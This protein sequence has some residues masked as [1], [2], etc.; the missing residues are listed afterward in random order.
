MTIDRFR[1][2]NRIDGSFETRYGMDG[3]TYA[4]L[5]QD[6]IEEAGDRSMPLEELERE[7]SYVNVTIPDLTDEQVREEMRKRGFQVRDINQS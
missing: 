7:K 5:V 2:P 3:E 4:K 1:R 6:G